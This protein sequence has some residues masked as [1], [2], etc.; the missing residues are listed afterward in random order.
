MLALLVFTP[1]AMGKPHYPE[2]FVDDAALDALVRKVRAPGA[3]I[4]EGCR[5]PTQAP[6]LQ[7]ALARVRA[8]LAGLE[9][10]DASAETVRILQLGDSH[11][12]ADYITS[13][14]RRDLQAKYGDG[15]RGFVHPDQ[16]WGYGGRRTAKSKSGWTTDRIVDTG[17]A[18]RPYG[19]S[20]YSLTADK[21]GVSAWYRVRPNDRRVRLF[22][23]PRAGTSVTVYLDKRK[24]GRFDLSKAPPFVEI[25]L[26]DRKPRRFRRGPPGNSL[27]VTADAKGVSL[28]G[29]SFESASRGVQYSVIGPVGA[30]AKVYL[31]LDEQSFTRHLRAYDP[32]L[33]VYM[34]GGNDAL[35]IRKRWTSLARVTRDHRRL[36]RLVRD[37]LP[38]ADCLLWAPMIAGR[39][40]G[41]RVVHKAYLTEVRDMQRKVAQ[42]NGCGFWDTMSAMG[43]PAAMSRWVPAMNDDLVHPRK[44][45]A[46]LVGRMF[47]RAWSKLD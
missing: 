39:R 36:L 3:A 21:A 19:F 23:R 9:R 22:F 42:E 20:G 2:P 46:D 13:R 28:Y 4:E 18:G 25:P 40:R 12:A 37:T 41:E 33:V 29:L 5:A 27:R 11:V 24:L 30:D 6:C 44:A 14:I 26:A 17:R 34:V 35:K 45:A 8:K 38:E 7:T 43:G 1:G 10:G 16:P 32:D 47:V 31:Q 15:G